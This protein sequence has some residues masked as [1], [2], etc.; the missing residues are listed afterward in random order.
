MTYPR[1]VTPVLPTARILLPCRR[2][3]RSAPI[4][5]RRASRFPFQSVGSPRASFKSVG[6]VGRVSANR[7][8]SNS[9]PSATRWA[10]CD[11]SRIFALAGSNLP[12]VI[13]PRSQR[14]S[15]V[16]TSPQKWEKVAMG[17]ERN[18]GADRCPRRPGRKFRLL[19]EMLILVSSETAIT[20]AQGWTPISAETEV[21]YSR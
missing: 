17:A 16:E 13:N 20:S 19:P 2:V 21:T 7:G 9:L 5:H 3:C 14:G 10:A 4:S 12:P 15:S 11:H 1:L 8:L 18:R 6:I